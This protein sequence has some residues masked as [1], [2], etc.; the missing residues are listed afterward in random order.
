MKRCDDAHAQEHPPMVSV[1]VA[2]RN[3]ERYLP[4]AL[5]SIEAQNYRSYEVIVIDGQ[6][7]DRT[8]SIAADAGAR[9][10]QQPGR[11]VGDA[12]NAGIAAARAPLVAFLSHDDRWTPDKLSVQVRL[13]EERSELGFVVAMVRYFVQ[14]GCVLPPGYHRE[15]LVRDHVGRIMETCLARRDVFDR[16]GPFD[17]ALPFGEDTDWFSRAEDL[18]VR[19]AVAPRVL[20]QKRLHD[21][22]TSSDPERSRRIM[23]E[24]VRRSIARKRSPEE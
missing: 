4:E 11:G 21:A 20:L 15:L 5:A 10:V 9:V 7:T 2:V 16:V 18:G 19:M 17:A 13:L 1:I 22:N 24:L 14:P 3:G 8:P 6:S 12:Y 23:L